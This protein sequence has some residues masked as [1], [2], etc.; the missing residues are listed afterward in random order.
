ME[1]LVRSESVVKRT[2]WQGIFQKRA[3]NRP[4]GG[5]WLV[6]HF[7]DNCRIGIEKVPS[8]LIGLIQKSLSFDALPRSKAN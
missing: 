1:G 5:E 3:S 2:I 7:S 4:R 6:R 8:S